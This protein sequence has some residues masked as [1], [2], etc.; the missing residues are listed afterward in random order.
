MRFKVPVLS[1][2]V[3]NGANG[4]IFPREQ[5]EEEWAVLVDTSPS[6]HCKG[7]KSGKSMRARVADEGTVWSLYVA[8]ITVDSDQCKTAYPAPWG[9]LPRVPRQS[10]P[11]GEALAQWGG[12]P[13][14]LAPGAP[15]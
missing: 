2:S 14:V 9:G 8:Q 15:K 10:L 7:Q 4:L 5:D 12:S 13:S 1:L 3:I 6:V 11:T